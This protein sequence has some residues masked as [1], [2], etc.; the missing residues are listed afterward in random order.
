V[1]HIG[2]KKKQ[3]LANQLGQN[4]LIIKLENNVHTVESVTVTAN[5]LSKEKYD[6]LTYSFS[7]SLTDSI[8]FTQDLLRMIPSVK[9]NFDR[10]LSINGNKKIEIRLN[11]KKVSDYKVIESLPPNIIKKIEIQT[12]PDADILLNGNESMIN[13]ITK[14]IVK[15]SF[16]IYLNPSFSVPLNIATPSISFNYFYKKVRLGLRGDYWYRKIDGNRIR[17]IFMEHNKQ[18]K[19]E[20]YN[21]DEQDREFW[22]DIDVFATEKSFFNNSSYFSYYNE[23]QNNSRFF[24]SEN[25][26]ELYSK[27]NSLSFVNSSYYLY[28][29]NTSRFSALIS[30]YKFSGNY[31]DSLIDNLY[32]ETFNS[33]DIDK[34][35]ISYKTDYTFKKD[36]WQVKAIYQ[37]KV[38]GTSFQTQHSLSKQTEYYN[39]LK[40]SYFFSISQSLYTTGSLALSSRI[41]E[42]DYNR[43]TSTNIL[44]VFSLNYTNK[45]KD[46]FTLLFVTSRTN[47]SL[48]RMN[49]L[50][51]QIEGNIF[52]KGNPAL[53]PSIN[54]RIRFGYSLTRKGFYN[55]LKLSANFSNNNIY[56]YY[57]FKN[58]SIIKTYSNH[59][60]M[61][62]F[63]F[64]NYSRIP[65]IK[66]KL[67]MYFS[68]NTSLV[69]FNKIKYNPE[70]STSVSIEYTP[71]KWYISSSFNY[72][73]KSYTP[74]SVLDKSSTINLTIF[75][76]YKKIMFGTQIFAPFNKNRT[77]RNYLYPDI[78]I[79]EINRMNAWYVSFSLRYR[80]NKGK[81]IESIE[82]ELNF[83]DDKGR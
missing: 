41:L 45:L 63:S 6:L 71:K 17:T 7:N 73:G 61:V 11:G 76:T 54:N 67:T 33:I 46:K 36:K 16:D 22:F 34:S 21:R 70:Y 38:N 69:S 27:N 1:S 14:S 75:K 53:K 72:N 10:T 66:S 55:N 52:A 58:D 64:A 28:D 40:A 43:T 3:I 8:G 59:S 47:P 78:A 44:P 80:F 82:R 65:I 68:L 51:F 5:L 56:P 48:W 30:L 83:D 13:I 77:I 19:T 81:K 49:P 2:Y 74:N 39:T 62:D 32:N 26:E 79:T 23:N 31:Q 24:S 9:V 60:D 20:K 18:I 37:G 15:P 35:Y 57:Q 12:T 42:T 50:M 4:N 29:G 25:T